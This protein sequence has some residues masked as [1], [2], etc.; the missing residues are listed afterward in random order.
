MS[1]T[2]VICIAGQSGSGKTTFIEKLI[3]ELKKR[4]YRLAVIKHHPHDFDI[5]VEGKDSWRY[6]QAGSDAAVVSAPHKVGLVKNVDHDLSPDE[7]RTLVGNGYDLIIIEGFKKSN[8]PKIEVHRKALDK[9]LVCAPDDLTAVAT[10]E[11]LNISAP[12]YDLTNIIGVADLIE[13]KFLAESL[14]K[15]NK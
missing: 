14:R 11:K 3:P 9:G 4:G 13:R 15:S 8:V 2:P 12:Q 7:L 10:D 5:D 1:A 6:M